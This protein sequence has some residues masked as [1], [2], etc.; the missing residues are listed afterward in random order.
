MDPHRFGKLDPVPDQS[1]KPD[2]HQSKKQDSDLHQ[3]EK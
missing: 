1:R 3:S 2:L